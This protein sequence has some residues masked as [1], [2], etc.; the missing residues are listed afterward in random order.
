[1]KKL[2]IALFCLLNLFTLSAAQNIIFES[3]YPTD[4]L[5]QFSINLTSEKLE[6]ETYYGT[7]VLLQ[8]DSNNNKLL[9]EI[10]LNNEK[11]FIKSSSTKS[12]KGEYCFIKLYIPKEYSPKIFNASTLSGAIHIS[13]LTVNTLLNLKSASGSIF[14]NK[15]SCADLELFSYSGKIQTEIL[16]S[17]FF[18]ITSES[19]ALEISLVSSPSAFSEI[20]STS[21]SVSL[22][23]PDSACIQ[24]SAITNSGRI[25]DDVNKTALFS[26]NKY[27]MPFGKDGPSLNIKTVSGNIRINPL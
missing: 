20:N 1:M 12:K 9:P 21:G 3:S 11:L 15:I 24:L 6:V 17:D 8:V 13:E 2:L 19:G 7:E 25:S 14:A 23:L 27:L 26:K 10:K 5:T 22:F 4:D 16:K 18:S